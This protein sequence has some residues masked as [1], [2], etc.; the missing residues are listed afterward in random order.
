MSTTMKLAVN[1]AT[2]ITGVVDSGDIIATGINY[3]GGK[4]ASSIN[5]AGGK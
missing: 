5:D 2:S 3:T 1:F 4:F